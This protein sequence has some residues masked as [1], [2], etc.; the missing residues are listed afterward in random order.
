VGGACQAMADGK[1]KTETCTS[2]ETRTPPPRTIVLRLPGVCECFTLVSFVCRWKTTPLTHEVRKCTTQRAQN[3][4]PFTQKR[5]EQ[6]TRNQVCW[7]KHSVALPCPWDS[8]GINSFSTRVEKSATKPVQL[9]SLYT[10]K[11]VDCVRTQTPV[12]VSKTGRIEYIVIRIF[13]PQQLVSNK[14]Q[15]WKSCYSHQLTNFLLLLVPQT[16]QQIHPNQNH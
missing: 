12:Q 15:R 16:E 9:S 13:D 11:P 10:R 5:V 6:N 1:T 3:M 7:R 14:I 8:E 4:L 2:Q